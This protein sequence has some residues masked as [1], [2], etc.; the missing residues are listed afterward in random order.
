MYYGALT[1]ASNRAT[2]SESYELTDSETGDGVDLT[3]VTE[4]VVEIVDPDTGAS[5]LSATKTG[6]GVVVV[7][8]ATDGVFQWRFE[9]TSMRALE[10]KQYEVGCTISQD[11]DD[12]QLIIGTL[13]ILDGVVS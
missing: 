10:A 4:I 9:S 6:G 11:G 5:A 2:W 8:S 3:S 12:V 7:G 13:S 1:P